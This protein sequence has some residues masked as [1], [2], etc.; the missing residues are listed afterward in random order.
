MDDVT[1]GR[2]GPYGDASKASGVAIPELSLMS[3]N[4][5]FKLL[6]QLKWT[7]DKGTCKVSLL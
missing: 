6:S 4:A 1:F 5:V 7:C 2:R 3:M